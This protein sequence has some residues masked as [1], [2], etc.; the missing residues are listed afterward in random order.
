M[1]LARV[2]RE[3]STWWDKV[4]Q[5]VLAVSVEAAVG[6]RGK[7]CHILPVGERL[8]E[9]N[10]SSTRARRRFGTLLSLGVRD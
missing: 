9:N 4:M 7:A 5:F 2:C 8:V 6:Q 1:A 3:V 10:L